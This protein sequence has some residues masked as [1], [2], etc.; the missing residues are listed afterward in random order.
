MR[1]RRKA[2][3]LTQ[4]EMAVKLGIA[5]VTYTNIERGK[6]DPSLR[7]ALLIKKLLKYDDDG[8]F[9]NYE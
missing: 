4:K 3:G 9:E 5:R 1:K 8:I 7:V 2:I 6:K